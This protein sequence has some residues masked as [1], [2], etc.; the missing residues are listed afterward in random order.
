MFSSLFRTKKNQHIKSI[1]SPE[2]HQQLQQ[3]SELYLIDVRSPQ[4]YA[5]GHIEGARLL[6]L[7]NL[8]QRLNEIPVILWKV[9]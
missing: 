1:S 8:Q 7:Q 3:G 9:V 2:L 6:P 5:S 4:E